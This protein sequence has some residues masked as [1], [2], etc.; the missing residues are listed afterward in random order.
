MNDQYAVNPGEAPKQTIGSYRNT[1]DIKQMSV[2]CA[3]M[4]RRLIQMRGAS[5]AFDE[6]DYQ[7]H[8]LL[9][10]KIIEIQGLLKL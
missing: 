6:S 9:S 5:P 3:I 2:D 1:D 8:R 7:R 10:D 4:L